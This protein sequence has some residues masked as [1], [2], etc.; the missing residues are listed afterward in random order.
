MMPLLK[1]ENLSKKFGGVKAVDQVNMEVNEGEIIGLIGPNGAGKSTFF[2][3]I[4]GYL[5]PESGSV[6]FDG[7]EITGKRADKI[8]RKG[9]VRTFQIVRPINDMTVLENTMVGSLMHTSSLAEARKQAM[10][11]LEFIGLDNKADKEIRELTLANKKSLELARTLAS[12][13]RLL[14]L[15]EVMA[16]L[17][18]SESAEA[19]ELI[20]KINKDLKITMI[21]VE[22]VMEVI[23]PLSNRVIVLDHGVKI[24]EGEPKKV[25]ND[26]NVIKAYLGHSKKGRE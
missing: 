20:K 5:I 12:K 21:I 25:I 18:P 13:P 22:H 3:A 9:M 10:G 8:A 17:T 23:M 24:A 4:S 7:N 16:G 26:E 11:I 19:V 1:V 2:A 15:D 6:I 14:L